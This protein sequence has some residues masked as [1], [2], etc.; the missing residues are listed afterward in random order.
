MFAAFTALNLIEPVKVEIKF[1]PEE[2]FDLVGLY[3]IS[4]EKLRALDGESLV[5]LNKSGF[6]QGACLVIA[7]LN[8]VKTLIDMKHNKRR[9]QTATAAAP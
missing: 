7:S 2:R 3:T 4:E 1:S 5:R 8:N 9:R 6:L